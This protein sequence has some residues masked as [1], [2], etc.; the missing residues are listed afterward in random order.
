[1]AYNEPSTSVP[2]EQATPSVNPPDQST[3]A[4]PR[5]QPD[6]DFRSAANE[7]QTPQDELRP[8]SLAPTLETNAGTTHSDGVISD[9]DRHSKAGTGTMTGGMSSISGGGGTSIFSSSNHSAHS[10]TTTLTTIQSAPSN[11]GN[12]NAQ[13]TPHGSNSQ[14]QNNATSNHH[15]TQPSQSSTYFQHQFPTTPASAVPPHLQP[16]TH[17]P[18]TYR[19]ATAHNLLSDNASVITLAS[20]SH[21]R[22]QR[23]NSADTNASIRAIAPSSVWGGS[24]ES[25]PL[26]VL[27]Q[28]VEPSAT[29]PTTA[30]IAINQPA[31]RSVSGLERNSVYSGYGGV[32]S[33]GGVGAPAL[34]SERNSI[35]TPKLRDA[36][37]TSSL[38][39]RLS[40]KAGSVGGERFDG[41]GSVRSG[42]FGH[43][44]NDSITGSIGGVSSPLVAGARDGD[45]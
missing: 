23:R 18:T 11:P 33:G 13:T 40:T 26:S 20:S 14:P 22:P 7:T 5:T 8:K 32:A 45:A 39:E 9:G 16:S 12:I 41:G 37:G 30:G 31:S 25:L 2:L 29:P 38:H 4:T 19:S 15:S 1:M 17:V 6:E 10:L 21:H 35:Y 36:D 43:G 42:Q 27:S 24:R 44:R 3:Y 28:S 34:Q